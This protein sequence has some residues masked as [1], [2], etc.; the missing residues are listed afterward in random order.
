MVEKVGIQSEEQLYFT[1]GFF[2]GLLAGMV[3]TIMFYRVVSP[4]KAALG[5][6]PDT[7]GKTASS[8]RQYGG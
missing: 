3:A 4:L 6:T 1:V 7:S 5:R 2:E 8:F